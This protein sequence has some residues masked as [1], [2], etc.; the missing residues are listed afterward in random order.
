ML[1][2]CMGWLQQSIFLKCWQY[3][4]LWAGWEIRLDEPHTL[5]RCW[6]HWLTIASTCWCY[7][8]LCGKSQ[9]HNEDLCSTYEATVNCL[10]HDSKSFCQFCHNRRPGW[11]EH[12]MGELHADAKEAFSNWATSGKARHGP[13][14]DRKKWANA[15]FRYAVRFLKRN[16]EA[17]RANS[18]A[19]ELRQNRTFLERS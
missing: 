16:E 14:F 19:K 13:E 12:C 3:E 8:I 9:K 7:C 10:V 4:Q 17:M 6:P 11:N 1:K 18:V 5:D 2:Y 15:R